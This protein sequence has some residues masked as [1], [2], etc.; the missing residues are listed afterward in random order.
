MEKTVQDRRVGRDQF[1]L[2]V[3]LVLEHARDVLGRVDRRVVQEE[4][5][6]HVALELRQRLAVVPDEVLAE[7]V[8]EA[9]AVVAALDGD[10]ATMP[11]R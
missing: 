6:G 3:C 7:E 1:Q 5:D 4:A 9:L 2:D 11:S 8:D 10:N